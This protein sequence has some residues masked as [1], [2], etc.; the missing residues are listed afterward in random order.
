MRR[1]AMGASL[2]E[3]RPVAPALDGALHFRRPEQPSTSSFAV[4]QGA[5]VLLAKVVGT[6]HHRTDALCGPAATVILETL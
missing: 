5:F 2:E 3:P 4:R 1:S 6:G